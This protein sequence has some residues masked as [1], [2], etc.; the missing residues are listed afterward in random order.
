MFD[1][2]L[3]TT[4]PVLEIGGGYGSS[5]LAAY[6][7]EYRQLTTVETDPFWYAYL[8]LGANPWHLVYPSLECLDPGAEWEVALVDNAPNT[9]RQPAIEWLRGRC[10]YL[11]VHDVEHGEGY[12]YD[13]RGYHV[14]RWGP[15]PETAVLTRIAGQ[16]LES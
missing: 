16:M 4:G 15:M 7:H 5:P 9:A 1:T 14:E 3:K 8:L 2:L 10:K 6:C 12:G 11:I 13:F